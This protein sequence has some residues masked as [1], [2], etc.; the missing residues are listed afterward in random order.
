M[1]L[2]NFLWRLK[3]RYLVLDFH[4]LALFYYFGA[5]MAGLGILGGG[6]SL[7]VGVVGT[8]SFLFGPH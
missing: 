7:S 2:K 5:A 4:P 8:E 3:T 6:W 1:L